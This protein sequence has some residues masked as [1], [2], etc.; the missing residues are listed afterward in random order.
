[1]NTAGTRFLGLSLDDIIGKD[2]T[3]LFGTTAGF[4]GWETDR[5]VITSGQPLTLETHWL[6]QGEI[7]ALKTTKY[8]YT[9]QE[10]T[11]VGVIGISHQQ[12]EN[13]RSAQTPPHS[14]TINTTQSL[15]PKE[16]GPVKPTTTQQQS[17]S[18]PAETH[19]LEQNR[20]LIALQSAMSAVT[21]SLDLN[22]VLENFAWEM[23][24]LLN[25]DDCIIF[26]WDHKNQTITKMGSYQLQTHHPKD[27]T[28][29]LDTF[30]LFKQVVIDR[31]AQQ[32]TIDQINTS[33]PEQNH[34]KMA[35]IRSL[36][37]LPMLLRGEVVGL[38]GI[39]KQHH[40][41]TF[42]DQEITVAQM[43]ANQ[44][45]SSIVNA[46][47]YQQLEET[48]HALQVSND[49]LDAFS[50]TVAHDLK[51]PLGIIIGFSSLITSQNDML[52]EGETLDYLTMIKNNG[53]KMKTII[54][55]LLLLARIRREDVAYKPIPMT[56][57][58]LEAKSRLL[59]MIEQHQAEIIVPFDLPTASGYAPWIEEVW[60]N[61]LSNGI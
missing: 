29:T 59:L 23:V 50:R 40:T 54:D 15:L 45:A 13:G 22:H 17:S 6:A 3:A 37:I 9:T 5:H 38:V 20:S 61:Y 24:Y 2:E 10:G 31:F 27:K 1:M 33:F 30:P 28:Y 58:I 7:C 12:E 55:E 56:A 46:Q 51:G 21:S 16:S 48:N 4:E 26:N 36:L 14:N 53:E 34:L 47:L 25:A 41:Y 32:I 57:C 52:P 44:A 43:L 18:A 42:S 8:P 19:I 11:I 49:E 35:G 39:I 60:V